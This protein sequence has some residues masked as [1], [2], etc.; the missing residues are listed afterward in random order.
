MTG[1]GAFIRPVACCE[2]HIC[3]F[4]CTHT[5]VYI[6]SLKMMEFLRV[7]V[8][9]VTDFDSVVAG[10]PFVFRLAYG[11]T[12]IPGHEVSFFCWFQEV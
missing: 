1:A 3:L 10:A 12:A 5:I 4:A 7:K 11:L 6:S 9:V 8:Q 2:P